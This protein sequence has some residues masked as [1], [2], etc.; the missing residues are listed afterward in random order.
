MAQESD[1]PGKDWPVNGKPVRTEEVQF[2]TVEAALKSLPRFVESDLSVLRGA[3]PVLRVSAPADSII[4]KP[5]D[6]PLFYSVVL[7]GKLRADRQE[8]IGAG[9]VV[10][11]ADLD[12]GAGR[13]VTVEQPLDRA[14]VVRLRPFGARRLIDE[15][16]A[17]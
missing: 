6:T 7:E 15:E 12:L 10:R 1:K 13:C 14:D 11:K 17:H 2:S 8:H 4:C 9:K 5:G 16:N 3:E